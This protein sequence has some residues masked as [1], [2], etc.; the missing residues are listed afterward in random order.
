MEEYLWQSYNNVIFDCDST[1]CAIE[2]IDELADLKGKKKEVEELTQKAMDG[3]LSFEAVFSKRLEIIKPHKNDLEIIGKMYID[4]LVEDMKEIIETLQFLGK[5]IYIVTGGYA[6]AVLTLGTDLKIPFDHIFANRLFFDSQGNYLGYQKDN[7]LCKNDGKKRV[8]QKIVGENKK[9]VFIGD[10]MTDLEVRDVVSRFIGYGGVIKR[11]SV[12]KKVDVYVESESMVGLLPYIIGESDC[13]KLLKS[14]YRYL[15]QKGFT[16][17]FV[18]QSV[19]F[20]N[21]FDRII[22]NQ[23][24]KKM[25]RYIDN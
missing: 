22:S 25:L 23:I 14:E 10:S 1:I 17:L 2:G 6:T 21:N 24:K 15:C 8:I 11:N 3:E 4:S 16:N 9:S 7:P 13:Q 20:N 12:F 5:S 19:T 18:E